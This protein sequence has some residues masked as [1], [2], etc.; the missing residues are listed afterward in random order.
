MLIPTALENVVVK[1]PFN[2]Q[3]EFPHVFDPRLPADARG[4]TAIIGNPPYFSIDATFGRGA[5][6]LLWLNMY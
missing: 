2:W 6:E 5:S 4:F 3:V 1:R